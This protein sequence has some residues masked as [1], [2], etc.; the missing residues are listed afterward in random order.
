M[1]GELDFAIMHT[2]ADIRTQ[3]QFHFD[4]M[5]RDPFVIALAPDHPLIR[6]AECKDGYPYPVLDVKLLKNE[7]FL[8]LHKSQRIR[9][10]TDEV[11]GRA[12]IQRP[13]ISLT[14]R[15][16]ETAQLLAAQGLSLI[17]I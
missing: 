14:L 2:P 4:I 7:S 1:S 13:K 17:H 11:L 16:F 5:R 15:N 6:K 3:P 10:I 8:M 9:Q 12:G